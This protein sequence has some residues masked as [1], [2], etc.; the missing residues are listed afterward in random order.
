MKRYDYRS[1][2]LRLTHLKTILA[3][4][5]LTNPSG[6]PI[7]PE[8][9][10]TRTEQLTEALETALRL[11]NDALTER[12]ATSRARRQ[13]QARLLP[14]IRASWDNLVGQVKAG[15]LAASE[16]TRYGLGA[17]G[18]RPQPAKIR[19]WLELAQLLIESAV[20]VIDK[21]AFTLEID[22]AQNTE[23]E[24]E[25]ATAELRE[26]RNAVAA[27]R[28]EVDEHLRTTAMQIRTS[29]YGAPRA[30]QRNAMRILGY[31]FRGEPTQ[32]QP[33][34]QPS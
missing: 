1:D 19:E 31:R 20:L 27:I 29:L 23:I 30:D 14:L 3:N 7:L 11:R 33:D 13:Q 2:D 17:T 4:R 6:Q 15:I 5:D 8:P 25:H 26:R 18:K 21:E 16:L 10:L 12:R 34:Q 9:S 24:A 22:R 32:P 28:T